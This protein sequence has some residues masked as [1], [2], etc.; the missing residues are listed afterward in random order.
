[1]R[2]LLDTNPLV[3]VLLRPEG[4]SARLFQRWRAAEFELVVPPSTL[5]ELADVL[6]RPHIL[7]KYPIGEDVIAR[8]LHVLSHFAEVAPGK[9]TIDVMSVDPKD[10]HVLAAAIETECSSIVSG[11][12]HLLSLVEY[13]GIRILSPR[14]FLTLLEEQVTRGN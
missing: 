7:K 14:D 8:H 2:V 5:A 4:P 3:S 9:L 11:D 1:M 12:H 6:R 13:R 10:N